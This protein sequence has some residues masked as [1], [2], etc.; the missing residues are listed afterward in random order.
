MRPS[1]NNSTIIQN[2][3][4]IRIYNSAE[5]VGDYHGGAPFKDCDHAALDVAF[6]FGIKRGCGFVKNQELGIMVQGAGDTN[7]LNLSAG[8]AGASLAY[9]IFFQASLAVQICKSA[10]KSNETDY[11]MVVF[12]I[13]GAIKKFLIITD[14][15]GRLCRRAAM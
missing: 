12:A 5:T 6:D 11:N 4:S 9:D 2:Q 8:Y 3:N 15:G 1:L 7:P 14:L 13:V 10:K